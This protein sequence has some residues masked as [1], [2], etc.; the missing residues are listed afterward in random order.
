MYTN[1]NTDHAIEI[2]ELWFKLHD[3]EIPVDFPQ[4]LV[5][6]SLKH[7]ISHNAFIF[8]SSFYIQE[9]GTAMGTSCACMYATI[10]YSYHEE[11]RIMKLPNVRFYRRLM[12]DAFILHKKSGSMQELRENM[13]EF[14]P[15]EKRLG[16]RRS[17]TISRLPRSHH[18]HHRQRH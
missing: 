8:G 2:I 16:H 10:Y 12:N 5:L 4:K 13:N 3:D 1:I 17:P 18:L 11:M 14:G 7:L 15:P 6:L 9:N